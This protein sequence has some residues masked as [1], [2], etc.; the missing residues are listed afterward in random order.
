MKFKVTLR[1]KD[2]EEKRI[3]YVNSDEE[4]I[5]DYVGDI[6]FDN[7]ETEVEKIEK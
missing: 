6:I 3:F 1:L 4:T 5:N 2:G 7:V